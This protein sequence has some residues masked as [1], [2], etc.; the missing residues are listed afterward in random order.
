MLSIRNIAEQ[1]DES[2]FQP[3][4]ISD[5]AKEHAEGAGK[6]MAKKAGQAGEYVSKKAGQAYEAAKGSPGTTAAIAAGAAGTAG[7]GALALRKL[8]AKK[9]AV[10]GAGSVKALK[11]MNY[12]TSIE[13]FGF[14]EDDDSTGDMFGSVGK[15]VAS[16]AGKAGEYVSKHAAPIAAGAAGA[17]GLKFLRKKAKQ[18]KEG[19]SGGG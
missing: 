7:A 12:D 18:A 3:K 14:G 4:G 17:L 9:N 11:E 15:K 1:D 8:R 10:A 13:E 2:W 6:Y 19:M 5:Q 16:A